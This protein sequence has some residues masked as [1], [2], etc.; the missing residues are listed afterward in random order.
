GLDANASP[1]YNGLGWASS[2]ANGNLTPEETVA[3][4]AQVY[5]RIKVEVEHLDLHSEILDK[6]MATSVDG[7]L[8]SLISAGTTDSEALAMPYLRA[9]SKMR[10]ELRRLAPI[11]PSK[12]QIL[13]L[14]DQ[15]R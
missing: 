4:Y 7:E 2:A 12:K 13:A 6:L 3:P 10:D 11:S 9:V 15:I 14:S 1:P 5:G 8:T